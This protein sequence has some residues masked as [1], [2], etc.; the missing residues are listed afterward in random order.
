MKY[1]REVLWGLKGNLQ[2]KWV[3]FLQGNKYFFFE[4]RN[5]RLNS[6]NKTNKRKNKDIQNP[7]NLII[8]HILKT[9]LTD[10]QRNIPYCY[11]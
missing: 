9:K 4:E 8:E 6:K 5:L 7:E 10:I 1:K 11:K 2:C 3:L